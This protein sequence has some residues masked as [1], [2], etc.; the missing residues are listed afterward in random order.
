MS[1]IRIHLC[2]PLCLDARNCVLVQ[3]KLT[4]EERPECGKG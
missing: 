1:M 3:M 2:G 4:K